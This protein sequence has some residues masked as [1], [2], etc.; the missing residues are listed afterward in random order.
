MK[1][2]ESDK[3]EKE[4]YGPSQ[5]DLLRP[6]MEY[7]EKEVGK[8][9]DKLRQEM[10]R[11]KGGKDGYNELPP[12]MNNTDMWGPPVPPMSP[13]SEWS[14]KILLM[15]RLVNRSLNLSGYGHIFFIPTEWFVCFQNVQILH[16]H[17]LI[18]SVEEV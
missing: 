16:H 12:P 3:M 14:L 9:M 2:E 18:N 7:L 15:E 17:C 13:P 8:A 11:E 5:G 4:L 1:N 6:I 10:E